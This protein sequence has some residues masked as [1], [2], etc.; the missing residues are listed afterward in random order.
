MPDEQNSSVHEVSWGA[1]CTCVDQ[2]LLTVSLWDGR[3]NQTPPAE[4]NL[5]QACGGAFGFTHLTISRPILWV[6][7]CLWTELNSA[8]LSDF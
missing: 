3:T 7:Q 6:P 2:M 1:V 8:G 5:A 4:P